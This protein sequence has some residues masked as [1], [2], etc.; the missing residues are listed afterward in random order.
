METLLKP[1][2]CDVISGDRNRSFGQYELRVNY[3]DRIFRA[4]LWVLG[5]FATGTIGAT[6]FT[7][8]IKADATGID[9][10]AQRTFTQVELTIP[11]LSKGKSENTKPASKAK[12]PAS[13][14]P[15]EKAMPP[16]VK[17]ALPFEASSNPDEKSDS[18]S[19]APEVVARE[20]RSSGI[21]DAGLAQSSGP[22]GKMPYGSN[23][24][25]GISEN[26]GSKYGSS[27]AV[28]FPEQEPVFNGNLENFLANSTR[29][30]GK[31]LEEGIEGQ[32]FVCFIVDENGKVTKPEIIKGIGYGCDEEALR[33]I[34]NLP[35]WKPGV[36]NGHPVKVRMRVPFRFK[37][38]R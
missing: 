20:K 8:E 13:Q 1:S 17:G 34:R 4:M 28:D 26:G 7:P 9:T 15:L 31:A 16:S 23:S 24:G 11:D 29:Y 36:M 5:T 27:D 35:D 25:N 30:P 22:Q 6:L 14:P 10:Q 21:P 37:L 18:I 12:P 19:P 33:V 38:R 32:V 2:Y 3:P